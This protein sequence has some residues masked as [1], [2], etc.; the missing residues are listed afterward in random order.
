MTPSNKLVC[1]SVIWI[2]PVACGGGGS[3]GGGGGGSGPAGAGGEF[4]AAGVGASEGGAAGA[5]GSIG[6]G[7]SAGA[8][9]GRGQ[10]GNSQGGAA[11]LAAFSRL[12]TG[13]GFEGED[14]VVMWANGGPALGY[15]VF[16]VGP[17]LHFFEDEQWAAS[18]SDPTSGPGVLNAYR[19]TGFCSDGTSVYLAHTEIGSGA[20]DLNNHLFVYRYRAGSWA[21]FGGG[22]VSLSAAVAFSPW[23]PGIVCPAG[24]DPAVTWVQTP[25]PPGQDL[26]EAAGWVATLTSSHFARSTAMESITNSDYLTDVRV[27][28]VAREAGGPVYVATWEDDGAGREQLFVYEFDGATTDTVGTSIGFDETA[29]APVEPYEPAIAVDSG[30][31]V[32]AWE[33][34]SGSDGNRDIFAARYNGSDWEPLGE[35]PIRGF[36]DDHFTSREPALAASEGEL[37]LAWA[38]SSESRPM[39]IFVARWT[40]SDW[41]RFGDVLNVDPERDT[42]DPSIAVHDGVLYVA[43]EEFVNGGRQIFVQAGAAVQ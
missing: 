23:E 33:A 3:G 11:V 25:A 2:A 1:V 5:S 9:A 41:E 7:G 8:S 27:T 39:S 6:E 36:D 24:D 16:D 38:E 19:L 14:P 30:H 28:G 34:A 31:P 22:E 37:Y 4:G 10:G 18:V 43:F 40:G 42:E 29:G 20:G 32:V 17:R 21:P 15:T 13:D 35:G 26:N 12:G